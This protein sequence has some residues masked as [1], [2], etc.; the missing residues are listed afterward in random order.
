MKKILCIPILVVLLCAMIIPVQAEGVPVIF[1]DDSN[2]QLGGHLTVD[3]F[4]MLDS[5]QIMSEQY[6]PLF[7]GNVIYVWYKNDQICLEGEDC[8]TL[9]LDSS[10]EGCTVYVK[11]LYYE[12]MDLT[13]QCSESVSG[14]LMITADPLDPNTVTQ[15][16]TQPVQDTQPPTEAAT[17]APE[18]TAPST[19]VPVVVMP[20]EET[21][22]IATP[23]EAPELTSPSPEPQA[24]QDSGWWIYVLVALV[25]L[26]LG[27][28]V[29]V[30]LVKRKK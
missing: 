9:E 14:L 23:T 15:P 22:P 21:I 17:E 24:P 13:M 8:D 26:G 11:V 10:F 16:Q 6:N 3:K 30:L 29:A 27:A 5:G 1:T 2:A 7:E 4:A 25:S 12:D 20:P 18:T 28:G 19:S